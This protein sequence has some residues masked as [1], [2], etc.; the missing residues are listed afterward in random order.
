MNTKTMTKVLATFL[1][2]I[3]SFAN[4]A[5]LG[6]Y[7]ES[8]TY[9]AETNLE[10]QSSDVKNTKVKFDAYFEVEEELVHKKSINVEG[11]ENLYLSLKV[12]E[13]Y[14]SKRKN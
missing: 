10:N 13:G 8:N 3:I 7:F 12:E 1:A 2:F 4:V 14:L 5:L 9:A 6:I 11:E